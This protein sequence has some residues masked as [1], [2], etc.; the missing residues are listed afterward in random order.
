MPFNPYS[1]DTHKFMTGKRTSSERAAR[2]RDRF[3]KG[4]LEGF[5][6]L[7]TIELLLSLISPAKDA[8]PVAMALMERFKGLRGLLDATPEEIGSV[9][10]VGKDAAALIKLVKSVS[11]CYLREKVEGR[12]VV[13]SP[14][15]VI[16]YLDITLSGEKT[17]KFLAIYLSARNEIIAVEV[18]HEGTVSHTVVYP[19]KAIELAFRHGARSVIFV[20][21]HPGGN[22][23]PSAAD[24][25]L[26]R[27]LQRA[28]LAV[29]LLVHDHI[30]IAGA[31]HC[32]ARENGWL[33]SGHVLHPRAAEGPED[34]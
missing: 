28:A 18:L 9:E 6:S 21:N 33:A 12:D 5:S 8:T 3:R 15:D 29:D 10:G 30:I 1:K 11:E 7:E 22:P 23:R 17:E 27:V 13:K 34:L 19:R 24:L 2:L 25:Q 31:L 14:K 20:H 16:D 4:S 32:S 26:M